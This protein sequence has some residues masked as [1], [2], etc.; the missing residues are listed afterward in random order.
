M[1]A[2]IGRLILPLSDFLAHQGVQRHGTIGPAIGQ[3]VDR[4]ARSRLRLNSLLYRLNLNAV[5]VEVTHIKG[6]AVV[7]ALVAILLQI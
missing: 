4:G 3:D 2:E 7:Q 5:P 6:F 1:A